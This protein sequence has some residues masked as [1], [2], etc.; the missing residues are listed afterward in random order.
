MWVT[1][2][3]V[4]VGGVLTLSGTWIIENRREKAERKKQRAAK[5]E[6]LVAAVYEHKHWLDLVE[7]IRVFGAAE[8]KP[9]SPFPK[10]EAIATVHFPQFLTKLNELELAA[11]DYERWML[12]AASKRLATGLADTAG[13]QDAYK[14]YS[15]KRKDALMEM[16]AYARAELQ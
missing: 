1:L 13:H 7:N 5:L 12:D 6:E 9:M 2:L 10:I 8:P 14:A 15:T 11:L 3:A 4:V 16:R